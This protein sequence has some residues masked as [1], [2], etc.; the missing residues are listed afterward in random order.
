MCISCLNLVLLW[1]V[2]WYQLMLSWADGLWVWWAEHTGLTYGLEPRVKLEINLNHRSL[3]QLLLCINT[4]TCPLL[5]G[6]RVN[7]YSSH[8]FI[9]YSVQHDHN[10]WWL[11]YLLFIR[12]MVFVLEHT[13][14]IIALCQAFATNRQCGTKQ[15]WYLHIP[16]PF[17]F[18]GILNA[19][20]VYLIFLWYACLICLK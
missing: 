10:H 7:S 9:F 4:R 11:S 1:C 8:S 20:W 14:L 2:Q 13:N 18:S 19:S 5:S 6:I 16:F 12:R 17:L 3:A 15:S